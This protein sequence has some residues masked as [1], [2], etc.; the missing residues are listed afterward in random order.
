MSALEASPFLPTSTSPEGT[1]RYRSGAVARMVRMPVATLR[2]WERRYGVTAPATTPTGHRLYTA[3]DVQRLAL[4]K[5]LTELGHAIGSIATLDMDQLREVATTHA[6]TLAGPRTAAA[7]A[8]VLWRVAV[9]GAALA[10]RLQSPSVLRRLGRPLE[11]IGPFDSLA[12]AGD[13]RGGE[14][15]QR[16]DALLVHAPGVHEGGLLGL[17]EAAQALGARRVAVLY[18]YASAPVCN[19]LAAAGVALLHEPQTDTAVGLWLRSLSAPPVQPPAGPALLPR[20][21]EPTVVAA[22]TVAPRRYDDATLADF[23][24]LSTTIACECPRHVAELL[25]QLS[26]FEAYSA[27]CAQRSPADAV[28]HSYLQQVAGAS[29]ALFEA[30]LGPVNTISAPRR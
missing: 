27:E 30:A 19:A 21:A 6:R 13:V 2:I 4:L 29:R 9:I 24:G 8:P 15:G 16:V 11:V 22:G 25:M 7:P 1:S 20:V 23:A 10:R 18:G 12:E 5:Q 17:Q 28:L 26:H 3:T 14:A